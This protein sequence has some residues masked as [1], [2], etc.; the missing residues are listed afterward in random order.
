MRTRNVWGLVISLILAAGGVV[1][2]VLS[3]RSDG[4][5]PLGIGVLLP[6]VLGI[7]Y[8]GVQLSRRRSE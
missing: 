3:L 1:V 7:I 5:L 4:A 8:F 6:G 2:F